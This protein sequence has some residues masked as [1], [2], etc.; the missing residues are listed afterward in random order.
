M[1]DTDLKYRAF[2]SYSHR[3]SAWATWLHARLEGFR[4]DKDLIGRETPVGPVP[5][6]LRPIFRDREDFSGGHTLADATV[7]ALDASAALIVLCSTVSAGRPARNKAVSCPPSKSLQ[8]RPSRSLL[9]IL[10][11]LRRPAVAA[12][13][14]HIFEGGF[15]RG[16]FVRYIRRARV[17]GTQGE[18]QFAQSAHAGPARD[19]GS[20]THLRSAAGAH[21]QHRPRR[22]DPAHRATDLP[23]CQSDD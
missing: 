8:G 22:T 21:G 3:D 19:R 2:L 17:A 10:G 16:V 13:A 6:T 23:A 7:T 15:T 14:I 9:S 1:P 11:V 18:G 20:R 12:D 5:K 4:I